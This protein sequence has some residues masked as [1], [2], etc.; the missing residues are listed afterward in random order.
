[1][2]LCSEWCLQQQVNDG[3]AHPAVHMSVQYL[4][5]CVRACLRTGCRPPL[6]ITAVPKMLAQGQGQRKAITQC[7][8]GLN[9]CPYACLYA[10]MYPCLQMCGHMS[11]YMSTNV[12]T[13]MST[14]MSTGPVHTGAHF[15]THNS[16]SLIHMPADPA[17]EKC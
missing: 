10:C 12:S 15:F 3:R 8:V 1:M 4:Y 7:A 5:K 6:D 2:L 14:Y 13:H 16:D 11:A 17:G 9:I